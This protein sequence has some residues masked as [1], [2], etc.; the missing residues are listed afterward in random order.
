MTISKAKRR[1]AVWG[2]LLLHVLWGV[3]LEPRWVAM[4][5]FEHAVPQW[6]GQPG[7]KVAVASDWHISRSA[8]GVMSPA[9]TRA[10]VDDINASVPDVILLPG[11]FIT[12]DR[13]ASPEEA[14][15]AAAEIAAQLGRL[16]APLGVYAVLGNHEWW[17]DGPGF[18]E[19]LRA[20]GIVVLENEAKAVDAG[21]WVVGIGD[22]FTGH[23]EP[24][25]ALAQVP[26]RA[27]VLVLTHDPAALLAMPPVQGLVVAGHTH[28]GQVSVPFYGALKIPS[29]APRTWAHGWVEHQGNRMYVTSGL[30]TSVLPVRFNMRP[31]WVLFRI[32]GAMG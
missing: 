7:L 15:A 24:E 23:S 19:A 5:E 8:W 29:E 12:A 6:Q 20:R 31:E 10:I 32:T 28:G 2:V 9:R 11:D 17:H 25:K 27:Q 16:R 13:D 18:A 3:V 1:I 4:R 22:R 30:G 26:A 14:R 21:L